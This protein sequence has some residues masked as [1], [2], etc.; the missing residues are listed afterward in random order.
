MYP[1]TPRCVAKEISKYFIQCVSKSPSEW[2]PP[3]YQVPAIDKKYYCCDKWEC[4]ARNVGFWFRRYS[5]DLFFRVLFFFIVENQEKECTTEKN[6]MALCNVAG[7]FHFLETTPRKNEIY[8]YNQ[9][10]TFLLYHRRVIGYNQPSLLEDRKKE[11]SFLLSPEFKI[12]HE[13]RGTVWPPR[14]L[15]LV[16]A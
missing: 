7:S 14:Q 5:T 9:T 4:I 10:P 13:I 3:E 8:L 6:W 1:V 12:H 11:K 16:A 15:R 2:E